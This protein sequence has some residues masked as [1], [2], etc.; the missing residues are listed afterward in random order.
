[1][2]LHG[3]GKGKYTIHGCYGKAMNQSGG[4]LDCHCDRFLCRKIG[5][6]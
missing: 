5:H 1:M 3:N 2:D 6:L 4:V